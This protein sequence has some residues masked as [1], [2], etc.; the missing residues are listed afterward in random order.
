M[1]L[2]C[3][4]CGLSNSP[5]SKFCN[6]C[7]NPLTQPGEPNLKNK[8]SIKA[9]W[10]RLST[11]AKIVIAGSA[12]IVFPLYL[13]LA[14]QSA[15]QRG[16]SQSERPASPSSSASTPSPSVSNSSARPS[17]ASAAPPASST[18]PKYDPSN[19]AANPIEYQL[20][21][22]D[23]KGY[24]AADDP[25]ITRILYLLETISKKTGDP[26]QSVG[27]RTA[28]STTVAK[29]N[30]GKVISNLEFLEQAN[31]MLKSGV[32]MKYE[33]AATMLLMVM[34]Q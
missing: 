21:Y 2:E 5:G 30:Y 10:A 6:Q 26:V 29:Q 12:L 19:P 27:D 16:S 17:A 3:L 25:K 34:I 9:W 13:I 18:R 22:L 32:K 11:L 20:A 4:Q 14:I 1:Y 28:K 8:G 15:S 31:E 7:S 24:V 33:D 23:S